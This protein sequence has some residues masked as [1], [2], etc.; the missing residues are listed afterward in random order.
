MTRNMD[1][2]VLQLFVNAPADA[3]LAAYSMLFFGADPG[4]VDKEQ[5]ENCIT[6]LRKAHSN[7]EFKRAIRFLRRAQSEQRLAGTT[8]HLR[9]YEDSI[10]FIR[11]ELLH[12]GGDWQA[13][14]GR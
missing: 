1:H 7:G 14:E 4:K 9:Y 10:A 8:E 11:A 13:T 12:R 6:A 2:Q 5:R 3:K